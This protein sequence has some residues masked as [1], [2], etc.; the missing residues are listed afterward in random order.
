MN[1]SSW[2]GRRGEALAAASGVLLA[3][4]FPKFGHWSLAW[5][6]LAP[7]LIAVAAAPSGRAAFRR[8]YLAGAVSSV[9]I[10][11]WTEAVVVQF[12][13][14]PLVVGVVVMLLL[15]LALALFP[16]LFAWMVWRWVRR[17]G[18]AGLLLA[19]LAWVATEILRAH[20]LFRFSWCLLGYSQHTNVAFI[21]IARFG[22][23]YAVSLVVASS[24]AVL[25]FLALARSPQARAGA[26]SGLAILV[27]AVA[28]Y[29]S[30]VLGR[31]IHS[32][33]RIRVGLVQA[34]ILQDEKWNPARAWDNIDRHVTL[35]QRAAAAGARF[36]VW[37]ESSVPFYFDHT[38]GLAAQ[39][40]QLAETHR[41]HLLFGNDDRQPRAEGG[42]RYFVGAKMLDPRGE[43]VLRYHKLRL[44]P[45]G[46]YVPMQPLLTMGG[47]YAAKL[48]DQ[49]ADFTPGSE[50]VVG[51]VDG[52]PVGPT[53]CYEAIFPDLV[54]GFAQ[55]GA[56]MLVNITNDGW[57]GRSSAPYQHLAMAS[58]RAVENGKYLVRAA[59]TGISAVVDPRGRV[60]EKTPLFE[61][62]VLVRDVPFVPGTTFYARHGDVFAWTCFALA[63][64]LTAASLAQRRP[65]ASVQ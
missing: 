6:A 61:A 52:H 41:I 19:P 63:A 11:Y 33:G 3:L 15:C 27:W 14:L 32:S 48:V 4:S 47:R 39:L 5:V 53:I 30:S 8:G 45:F 56:E 40:Q 25:A 36:V 42:F 21:Q 64:M 12:G 10:V 55:G 49:V 51:L 2:S 65:V 28:M 62:T 43:L 44:V 35:T 24:S 34:S 50:H 59:N 23:V 57:Y 58:F 7:L 20:T 37:P 38:P 29:G 54:R 31:P 9:G 18:P 1:G 26:A 13:G 60:V 22:A 17:F 46:E 16:S